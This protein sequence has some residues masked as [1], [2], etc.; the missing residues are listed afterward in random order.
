M[1]V[2][3]IPSDNESVHESDCDS[4][5]IDHDEITQCDDYTY[6][7]NKE[8]DFENN[9]YC[10]YDYDD[11]DTPLSVRYSDMDGIWEKKLRSSDHFPFNK[12]CGPNVPDNVTTPISFFLCLLPET[13][14][15][16]IVE[17]SN[18]YCNQLQ[19]PFQPITKE[20]IKQFIGINIM[21]GI[22]HLPS[23]R[24]YWSSNP[25]LRDSYI[26]SIMPVKRFSFL[27]ATFHLNDNSLEPKKGEPDYDKLYKLRPFLNILSEN[28][29]KFY[30]PSKEQ[31]IDESMIKYKGRS[32][33]KQYIPM[34]PIKRGYKVW[35]R[36]DKFGFVCDFQI[37]TGKINGNKEKSLG[38]R[39]V[40]DLSREL[41]NS[42]YHIYFDNY[43]T[44]VN[45]MMTLKKNGILACGCVRSHRLGLPKNRKKDKE[46]KRSESDWRT[47]YKGVRW[48]I[49]IDKRPVQFLSNFQD[50]SIITKVNRRQVDGSI[51]SI[52]CP[53]IVKDY[54]AHMGYVDKADML[55]S[56]YAINRKS[57]KWWPRIFWHF[58]DVTVV[59]AFIM[60]KQQYAN[61][62]LTLKSF[63]LSIVDGFLKNSER[64]KR[65]RKSLQRSVCN[66]KPKTPRDIRTSQTAHMPNITVQYRRCAYCSTKRNESRTQYSCA[67]CKVPLCIKQK[68]NCF[69]KFHST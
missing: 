69:F 26:S 29:K 9:D 38:E 8:S 44:S 60:F 64:V 3:E 18:R 41:V 24:D 52:D 4:D 50:P 56:V 17:Q 51:I 32:T 25:Q 33:I 39:V 12:T 19:K 55:K 62:P 59:N 15:E 42:Y 14:L 23:Y 68:K 5:E 10:F 36:A 7:N 6:E 34:K 48:L 1:E 54:N 2:L 43:F 27:L 53:Q 31:S 20:E 57:K 35:V 22:K 67:T 47:S 40:I 49:W 21:M 28:Y 45:L 16:F 46:M 37:Y 63:R 65:G 61:S 58:I 66:F 11:D 13:F 30:N